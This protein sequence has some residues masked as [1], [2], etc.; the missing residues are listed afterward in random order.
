MKITTAKRDEAASAQGSASEVQRSPLFVSF[1]RGDAPPGQ[2]G[3]SWAVI[4]DA[5]PI[6]TPEDMAALISYLEHEKGCPICII[7]WRRLETDAPPP[8]HEEQR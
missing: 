8:Q 7:S 5:R 1:I 3:V 4:G 2:L 6:R